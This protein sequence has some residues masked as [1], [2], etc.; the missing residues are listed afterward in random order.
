M[1]GSATAPPLTSRNFVSGKLKRERKADSR[2]ST[3]LH[4][5]RLFNKSV[6]F[7]EFYQKRS[8]PV[9]SFEVFPPKTDAAMQNLEQ[10]LPEI[11]SLK[12]DF[13]TVTYGALGSTQE[14]TLDI[15]STIQNRFKVPTACHLTCVGSSKADLDTILQRI[16]AAGIRNI[17]AL[18]GDPP[19]GETK[20]VAPKDG[21]AHAN[22]LVEFIRAAEKSGRIGPVGIAV[23]GYPEKHVEAPDLKTDLANLK[24]KVD[25][26]ADC[27]VTQ[28]FYD[29][30]AYFD[31]VKAARDLGITIPIVPGLL[32]ILSAKQ[33]MRI[34]SICGS[35]LPTVLKRDLELAGDDPVKSEQIGVKQCIAQATELLQK[36]APGIHFYV[37]NK[38]SHMMRIMDK[39]PR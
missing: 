18:R 21:L 7:R 16:R 34:T 36:G 27:V 29:N 4:C 39:L 33:V 9:I 1:A 24:R 6:I 31:F 11:V 19:A 22:E 17:V 38:S 14:R 8:R 30:R 28:L 32:P 25:A 10:V 35:C 15:A 5:A 37:L 20:F 3:C 2:R 13:M 12:P 23:A 26:G